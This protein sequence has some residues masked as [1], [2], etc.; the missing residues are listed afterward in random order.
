MS[1]SMV[2][3]DSRM[4]CHFIYFKG[5]FNRPV[6]PGDLEN[7]WNEP[8]L[9]LFCDILHNERPDFDLAV[10]LWRWWILRNNP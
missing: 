9:K 10:L 3:A 6:E 4:G 7:N 8:N 1:P 2:Y 5:R